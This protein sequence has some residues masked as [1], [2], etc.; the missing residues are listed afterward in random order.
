M[1]RIIIPP[2]IEQWIDN[3][4]DKNTREFNRENY[5]ANLERTR[6]VINVALKKYENEKQ[7]KVKNL[8]K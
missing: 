6:D 7:L 4:N 8:R 1:S 5:A 2:I 3:L